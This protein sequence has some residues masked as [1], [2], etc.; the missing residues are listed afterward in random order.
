MYTKYALLVIFIISGFGN[1]LFSFKLL[2]LRLQLE[3]RRDIVNKNNKNFLK[4]FFIKEN[5]KSNHIRFLF[6]PA[7]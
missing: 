5:F 1:C 6:K 7:A 2:F 3:L 4:G